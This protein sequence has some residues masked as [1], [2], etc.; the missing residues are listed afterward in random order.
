[1]SKHS[2]ISTVAGLG[3]MAASMGVNA[4][5]AHTFDYS[6]M[7]YGVTANGAKYTAFVPTIT[8]GAT[9]SAGVLM[10]ELFQPA[11]STAASTW[12]YAVGQAAV[13]PA[14]GGAG[15]A[16]NVSGSLAYTLDNGV[17]TTFNFYPGNN[18][19]NSLAFIQP[20]TIAS[21]ACGVSF[22]AVIGAD[23][24][25][26]FSSVKVQ[27][28]NGWSSMTGDATIQTLAASNATAT[29][30]LASTAWNNASV[31]LPTYGYTGAYAASL[32]GVG[33]ADTVALGVG[34]N[35]AALARNKCVAAYTNRAT[36]GG[37]TPIIG[38]GIGSVRLW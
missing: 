10:L 29:V 4:Q 15:S 12:A 37:V 13:G 35:A 31:T 38:S 21:Q 19:E 26:R 14:A 27:P 28:E 25:L 36:G 5:M 2:L 32:S 16:S 3:L 8:R 7:Y 20:Q 33:S 1:M 30:A 34:G 9:G 24:Q 22:N 23:D 17:A 6:S 18:V 11:A